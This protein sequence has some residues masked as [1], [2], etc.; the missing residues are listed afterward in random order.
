ML[1]NSFDIAEPQCGRGRRLKFW[2]NG[3]M[4]SRC[5]ELH[6]NPNLHRSWNSVLD[7]LT[8]HLNPDFGSVQKV[9]NLRTRKTVCCFA[10]LDPKEK[11]IVAPFKGK[12]QDIKHG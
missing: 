6:I 2:V 5:Y 1:N 10:D 9:F 8:E 3:D 7:Y 4:Y 12:L 11:Y